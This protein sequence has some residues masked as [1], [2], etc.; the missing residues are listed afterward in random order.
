MSSDQPRIVVGLSGGL[1]NQMFQ[2]AAG[3]ALSLRLSVPLALDLSWFSGR[4]DRVYALAPFAIAATLV[5]RADDGLIRW[6]GLVSR[7]ARRLGKKRLGAPIFRERF[8]SFDPSLLELSAPAY[9][10]GY[11]QSE[12]YFSEVR[13]VV[14][15]D[16]SLASP[17]GVQSIKMLDLVSTS[18]AICVHVRRGDYVTNPVASAVHGSCQL[19]YYQQGVQSIL[20]GMANPHCFVFSDDSDWVRANLHLP[21]PST[22][23]DFNA[24]NMAHEDL[25]L[26]AAC[27]RFVLANSSFS[28]WGAWLCADPDKRIIAPKRWF[29]NN[30][31]DT[32]DL[33][34][35]GWMRL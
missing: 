15:S 22:I 18:D 25:R 7:V 6:E 17:M 13:D 16:F 23:V 3:R 21:V 12:R 10:E 27:K 32:R 9:L 5:G 14:V 11:W 35:E 28:W 8:F 24:G 4:R 34:P 29:Q 19:D 1:G 33:I 26:M 2:Y 20:D 30:A 31:K